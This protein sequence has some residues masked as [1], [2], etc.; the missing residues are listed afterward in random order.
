MKN[1]A[2]LSSLTSFD[3][4][5]TATSKTAFPRFRDEDE[6]PR[7]DRQTPRDKGS[8]QRSIIITAMHLT[9]VTVAVSCVMNR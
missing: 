8:D 7:A 9:R 1:V 4:P 3:F 2:P 6:R 5:N